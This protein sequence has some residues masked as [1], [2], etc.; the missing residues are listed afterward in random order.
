MMEKFTAEV[1]SLKNNY[2]QD[3]IETIEVKKRR[4]DYIEIV[5][6]YVDFC[7]LNL[8]TTHLRV[9]LNDLQNNKYLQ[10]ISMFSNQLQ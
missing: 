9:T 4:K 6:K 2:G 8:G 1:A 5:Y 10:E 7:L 3:T